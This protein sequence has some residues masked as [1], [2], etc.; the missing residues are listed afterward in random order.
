VVPLDVGVL[1]DLVRDLQGE[2][3]ETDR[4]I[5]G[6]GREPVHPGPA[7]EQPAVGAAPEPH[8]MPFGRILGDLLL[9]REVLPPVEEEQR[10][11]GRLVVTAP[12]EGCGNDLPRRPEGDVIRARP[13]GRGECRLK[14]HGR[15]G[16][17]EVDGVAEQAVARAGTTDEVVGDVQLRQDPVQPRQHEIGKQHPEQH[18]EPERAPAE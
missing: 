15:A 13:A 18:C 16:D 3:R 1:V 4:T 11:D 6:P 12:G 7:G 5:E 9:V 8:V 14:L 17:R 2:E 10:A